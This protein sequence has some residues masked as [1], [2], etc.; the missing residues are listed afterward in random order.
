MSTVKALYID[1]RFN[2]VLE[3]N[4][5]VKE[6]LVKTATSCLGGATIA[7][8]KNF[9]LEGEAKSHVLVC[10]HKRQVEAEGPYFILVS[11]SLEEFSEGGFIR[12][13]GKAL[14]FGWDGAGK[15]LDTDIGMDTIGRSI[16]YKPS[17]LRKIRDLEVKI[18]QLEENFK[19]L[20]ENCPDPN[21][22]LMTKHSVEA[23]YWAL[24]KADEM[25]AVE[26]F[27]KFLEKEKIRVATLE[28][29]QLEEAAS[30]VLSV[31]AS[32]D[33]KRRSKNETRV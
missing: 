30:Q 25:P 24:G 14:I 17:E 31:K 21:L 29:K 20:S 33:S 19:L 23:L 13:Y 26:K 1:P 6:D 3:K 4:I 16:S 7:A 18:A 2:R 28:K 15:L 8:Y 32:R 12:I 9:S 5:K 27:A 11:E 22:K 10:T